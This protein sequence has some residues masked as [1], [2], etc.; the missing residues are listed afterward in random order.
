MEIRGPLNSGYWPPVLQAH[1]DRKFVAVDVQ[2]NIEIAR[3][4]MRS[5]GVM[6]TLCLTTCQNQLT[7]SVGI[8]GP[9]FQKV[10]QMQGT[11][12]VLIRP[13]NGIATHR[14]KGDAIWRSGM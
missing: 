3:V 14:H 7:D 4:E 1:P 2:C 9:T 12:F 13:L 10:A 11:Q 6:E 5:C 8:T